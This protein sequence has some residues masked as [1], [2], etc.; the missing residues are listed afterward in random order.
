M[1]PGPARHPRL[2]TRDATVLVVIDVQEGY[3]S[4]LFEYERVAA[5][6]AKIVRGAAMLGVPILVTEQYPKGVGSTV[7]EVSR[8]LPPG[9]VPIQKMSRNSRIQPRI[10]FIGAPPLVQCRP[11]S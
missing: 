4:V 6:V 8:Q 2:L 1:T 5:A 10:F 7:A 3:R 9:T 11:R